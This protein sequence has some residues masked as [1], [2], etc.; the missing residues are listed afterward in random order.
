MKFTKLFG[1]N[2]EKVRNG[3]TIE[4]QK[5]LEAE[6][7]SS[8]EVDLEGMDELSKERKRAIDEVVRKY[9]NKEQVEKQVE[10]LKNRF[11]VIKDKI[12][13]FSKEKFETLKEASEI[14]EIYGQAY[15]EIGEILKEAKGFPEM[16]TGGGSEYVEYL[17][18]LSDLY[19]SI[20][21]LIEEDKTNLSKLEDKI[22]E[23]QDATEVES[24]LRELRNEYKTRIENDKKY[25]ETKWLT[26]NQNAIMSINRILADIEQFDLCNKSIEGLYS[27]MKDY[28]G[29]K[30]QPE[31]LGKEL[32]NVYS[33][34]ELVFK[35]NPGIKYEDT[36]LQGYFGKALKSFHTDY[37]EKFF[38]K[39]WTGH[40]QYVNYDSLMQDI[41]KF[42]KDPK[43]GEHILIETCLEVNHLNF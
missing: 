10:S 11:D 29:R 19:N 35:N 43:A 31:E 38:A 40:F 41:E 18:K 15:S 20:D 1:G 7:L 34:E 30:E 9:E 13:T 37:T 36:G 6:D 12:A 25:G 21:R 23:I 17:N 16:E 3:N 2:K 4:K 14:K 33:D 26:S 27:K 8:K 42:K 32:K 5:E 22:E 28:A 24:K 39:K